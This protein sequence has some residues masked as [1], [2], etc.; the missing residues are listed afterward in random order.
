MYVFD[1]VVTRYRPIV[2]I[3][4]RDSETVELIRIFVVETIHCDIGFAE[5]TGAFDLKARCVRRF[6][7]DETVASS[8]ERVRTEYLPVLCRRIAA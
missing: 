5:C 8:S 7:S 3:L 2:C 4:L 6:F 1:L